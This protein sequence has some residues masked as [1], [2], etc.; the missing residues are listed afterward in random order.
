MARQPIRSMSHS[1]DAPIGGWNAF[2][3]MDNMPPD[4]AIILD[5]MIPQAGLVETRSGHDVYFDLETD[6][7]VETVA[8]LNTDVVNY[9]IAA[10]GGGIW[11]IEHEPKT[12]L[13]I[14]I[15]GTFTSDKWQTANFRNA[16]EEGVLIM[17]NGVDKAQVIADP[18][19]SVT[20][21]AFTIDDGN[22]VQIPYDDSEF[23]GVCNFKGRCYY[24]KDNDDSFWYCQAGGYTGEIKEFDLGAI[25]Q[26]GGKLLF[27]TTWTQQ[28]SGDGKDDFAVF[29][30]DTGEILIYQGD[31]PESIGFWEM[32]GRYTTAEP[33]SIRGHSKYGSDTIIMTMDGY[34]ALSTIVQEGRVSDVPAFSRL[35]T[36]AITER[37]KIN[38]GFYGW[39]AELFAKQGLFLFNVPL[40]DSEKAY[41]QHVLNT[42]TQRWCRFTEIKTISL[43]VSDDQL[44]GGDAFGRVLRVLS[45]TSDQGNAIRHTALPA[46]NYL[47]DAGN[48]KHISA[49]QVISTHPDPQNIE[50]TGYA[51]FNY[52]FP[53]VL[54]LPPS[55]R[56]GTWSILP[57][58]P[59]AS[60]GS[61][62]DEDYWATGDNPFTTK[63][64]QNVSAFGYAVSVMVRFLTINGIVKW[65]SSTIRFNKAGAH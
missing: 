19:T 51:D 48:R 32:I 41:E 2:D 52:K 13:N 36:N 34:V 59:A 14:A 6:L 29:V 15:E 47:G 24:W 11:R 65:R 38:S 3:S 12:L 18:Y 31:D 58:S 53:P 54:I 21:L 55:R 56:Q 5:N 17:C 27:M 50:L 60:V 39:D 1:I 44:Y 64:W 25:A 16:A 40:T 45:G 46:F 20:P 63:G 49:A 42:V 9:L 23:I 62:W 7:P 61:Y 4:A 33:L 43:V 26:K 57:P 37:T 10:S 8:N 22:D 30:M 28:D 35:I